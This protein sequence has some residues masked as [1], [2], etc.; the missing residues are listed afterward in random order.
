MN[1]INV[2]TAASILF[3]LAALVAGLIAAHYWLKASKIE[4]DP[5]WRVGYPASP[6]DA[7]RSI[8]PAD[9]QLSQMQWIT[10]T[11]KAIQESGDLNKIAARWTAVAV[12]FAAVSSVLGALASCI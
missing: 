3:A 5:G 7:L 8:E 10:E 1:C 11:M 6:A 2:L 4:I 12:V 9:I